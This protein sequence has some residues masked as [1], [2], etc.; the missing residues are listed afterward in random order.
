M[1]TE[2]LEDMW[3]CLWTTSHLECRSSWQA[4]IIP[5]YRTVPFAVKNISY[6]G[7]E[8]TP[9][10]PHQTVAQWL[11]TVEHDTKGYQEEQI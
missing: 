5:H 8:Y 1:S 9:Y 10:S 11:V 3:L 2:N 7:G 4:G 6:Y